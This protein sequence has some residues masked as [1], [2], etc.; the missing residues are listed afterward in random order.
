[1]DPM[2][3]EFIAELARAAVRRQNRTGKATGETAGPAGEE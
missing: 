3:A 1:M 2:I